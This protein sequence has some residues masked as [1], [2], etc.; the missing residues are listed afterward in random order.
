MVLK[1][2]TLF[3][4]CYLTILLQFCNKF[5]AKTI[6]KNLK[7][8]AIALPCP[9]QSFLYMVNMACHS[10]KIRKLEKK[11]FGDTTSLQI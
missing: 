6:L 9:S 1:N 11:I 3:D 4:I 2:E 7:F 5:T 8:S 10:S